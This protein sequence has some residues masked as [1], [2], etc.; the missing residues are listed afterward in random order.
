MSDKSTVS[1]T[2]VSEKLHDKNVALNPEAPAADGKDAENKAV[3]EKA[4]D[5][6]DASKDDAAKTAQ[7]NQGSDIAQAI[8][9]GFNNSK[10]DSFKLESD[11]G[12][13]SR[14]TLVKNKDGDVM[15]RENETGT[16]SK[17]QLQSIEEK[18]ASIQGQEVEEL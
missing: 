6:R 14:F 4:Q 3:A 8:S 17:L 13:E 5:H 7:V 1:K 12:V 15:L 11:T 10:K 16:L 9:E 18:E 2:A